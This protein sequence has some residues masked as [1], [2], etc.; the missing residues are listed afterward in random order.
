MAALVEIDKRIPRSSS[1]PKS[2]SALRSPAH[3]RPAREKAGLLTSNWTFPDW[4]LGSGMVLCYQS[5]LIEAPRCCP[6]SGPSVLV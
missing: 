5:V 1:L 6:Y 3:P 2:L 4:L